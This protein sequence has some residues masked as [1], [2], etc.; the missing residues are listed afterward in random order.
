MELPSGHF[1]HLGNRPFVGNTS[2]DF[3]P[4]PDVGTQ[5]GVDYWISLRRLKRAAMVAMVSITGEA[6]MDVRALE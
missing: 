6:I 2:T 1:E 3:H 5:G 4:A